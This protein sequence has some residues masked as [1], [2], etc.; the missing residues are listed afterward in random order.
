MP[1]ATSTRGSASLRYRRNPADRLV[2][3][4]LRGRG[5]GAAGGELHDGRVGG[6]RL[7]DGG[8]V[9][10]VPREHRVVRAQQRLVH[11]RPVQDD[12]QPQHAELQHLGGQLQAG[13]HAGVTPAQ[14]DV[15][16][17]RDA[18]GPFAGMAAAPHHPAGR[19]G[20]WF[21][22]RVRR[23]RVAQRHAHPALVTR[24]VGVVVDLVAD[25]VQLGPDPARG[26]QPG[27]LG[28]LVGVPARGELAGVDEAQHPVGLARRT[29]QL[30]GG[31]HDR[32]EQHAFAARLGHVA[33][34]EAPKLLGLAQYVLR[35]AGH[36]GQPGHGVRRHL[37]DGLRNVGQVGPEPAAERVVRHYLGHQPAAAQH[38]DVVP[39]LHVHRGQHLGR[40]RRAEPTRGD[41]LGE[42]LLGR[43]ADGDARLALQRGQQ[44]VG[45]HRGL[46]HQRHRAP[47]AGQRQHHGL[48]PDRGPVDQVQI[49]VPVHQGRAGPGRA[50]GGPVVT[51][52][53]KL[54]P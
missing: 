45:L 1:G 21:A 50:R 8:H 3:G 41:A 40:L 37:G 53:R 19:H 7:G 35:G 13:V 11:R 42:L 52:R 54:R 18:H 43:A 22:A 15:A 24:V 4:V 5:R 32:R 6:G 10:Q 46:Q 26:Q 48:H 29:G 14:P 39:V 49:D 2:Q 36:A 23:G 25:H 31:R 12:R 34:E 9:A 51:G 17:G 38:H 30:R 27:Q 20:R 47:G 44:P 33:L 16:A 28:H